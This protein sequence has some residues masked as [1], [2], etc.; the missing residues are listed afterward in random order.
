MSRAYIRVI[1]LQKRIFCVSRGAQSLNTHVYA[2]GIREIVV[3]TARRLRISVAN[4]PNRR[5]RAFSLNVIIILLPF[6][7]CWCPAGLPTVK[8]RPHKSK[9]NNDRNIPGVPKQWMAI[10]Q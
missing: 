5:F 6:A 9:R 4:G 1:S 3:K 10:Y 8:G 7:R 2:G